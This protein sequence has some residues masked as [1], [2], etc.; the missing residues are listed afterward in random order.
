MPLRVTTGPYAF[1]TELAKLVSRQVLYEMAAAHCE[2]V[3]APRRRV[4]TRGP[5]ANATRPRERARRANACAPCAGRCA[6]T[7]DEAEPPASLGAAWHTR[8]NARRRTQ[9]DALR[10]QRTNAQAC[11]R[12]AAAPSK[13]A[14]THAPWTCTS[15]AAREADQSPLANGRGRWLCLSAHLPSPA[16][17]EVRRESHDARSKGPLFSHRHRQ[18]Y[19]LSGERYF[20]AHRVRNELQEREVAASSARELHSAKRAGLLSHRRAA[21]RGASLGSSAAI[22]RR[23]PAMSKVHLRLPKKASL[24]SP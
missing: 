22:E 17:R 19:L 10:R 20:L 3:D 1:C 18:Q 16:A 9:P 8:R 11:R 24:S 14:T 6:V 4:R 2:G 7:A 21:P 5:R 15:V 13:A 23:C 12:R